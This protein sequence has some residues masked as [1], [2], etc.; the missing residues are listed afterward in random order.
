[1]AAPTPYS[2]P[3]ELVAGDGGNLLV[4]LTGDVRDL[5]ATGIA[6][7]SKPGSTSSTTVPRTKAGSASSNSGLDVRPQPA[8]FCH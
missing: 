3:S 5:R 1:M 7:H 4:E 2:F 8:T 6:L